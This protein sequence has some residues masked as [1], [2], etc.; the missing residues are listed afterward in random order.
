MSAK[1]DR[2]LYE[3]GFCYVSEMTSINHKVKGKP[4]HPYTV[5]TK[6]I[7]YAAESNCGVLD[8]GVCRAVPCAHKDSYG[9]CFAAYEEHTHD[10]V[11]MVYLKQSVEN[12]R[13]GAFLKFLLEGDE[14]A[15]RVVPEK[16]DGFVFVD[17]CFRIVNTQAHGE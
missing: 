9:K 13:I 10:N 4:G 5:G 14:N 6:H 12:A 2:I 3:N 11:V 15:D 1:P 16:L 7:T 17:T 8:E